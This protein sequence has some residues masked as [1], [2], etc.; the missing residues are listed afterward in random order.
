MIR[1]LFAAGDKGVFSFVLWTN[2]AIPA[3]AWLQFRL[4]PGEY[5][6][7]HFPSFV[8]NAVSMWAIDK[9]NIRVRF[10]RDISAG[11]E[12]MLGSG[13]FIC[14]VTP[15]PYAFPSPVLDTMDDGAGGTA[16]FCSKNFPGDM[17]ITRMIADST[18]IGRSATKPAIVVGYSVARS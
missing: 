18:P 8:N 13:Q 5:S 4:A 14:G 3:T 15:E 2:I 1:N 6:E 7:M 12:I 17:D 9:T 16:L 10:Q 11:E